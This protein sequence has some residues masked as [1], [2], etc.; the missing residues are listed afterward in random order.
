ML[1][2]A[3]NAV[4]GGG[5]FVPFPAL[6]F[7]GVP[8]IPANATSTLALWTAAADQWRRLPQQAEYCQ[9]SADPTVCGKSGGW[10]AGRNTAAEDTGTYLHASAAVADP[11]RD[12]AV[13]PRQTVGRAQFRNDP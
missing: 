13:R 12:L 6:L 2:G 3:L 1:G 7:V 4:A 8:P 11:G 9:T 5:S 10:F